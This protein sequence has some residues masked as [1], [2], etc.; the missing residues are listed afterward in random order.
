M[1]RSSVTALSV[2]D[3][4]G[5][6]RLAGDCVVTLLTVVVT[7]DEV[8]VSVLVDVHCHMIDGEGLGSAAAREAGARRLGRLTLG[9]FVLYSI[10]G[11]FR[12]ANSE[13][14]GTTVEAPAGHAGHLETPIAGKGTLWHRGG[15]EVQA[16][17]LLVSTFVAGT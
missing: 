16:G 7:V 5:L 3:G 4:V 13:L 8:D 15:G 1:D 6:A 10:A 12:A 2:L 11:E 9:T 14:L 17:L